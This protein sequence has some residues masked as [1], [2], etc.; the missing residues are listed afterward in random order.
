M[1]YRILSSLKTSVY[2]LSFMCL[3]FLIGTIF[4]QGKDIEEYIEAGGKYI[5]LVRT[6]GFLD[7]FMSP[8]F[9]VTTALLVL[10]LAICIYE[11]FRMFL[12][13]KKK[14]IDLERLKSHPGTVQMENADI[15]DRLKKAGFRFKE[16][17]YDAVQ[18]GIRVYEKGLPYWW[19]SWFYHVGIILAIAGFFI[20]AL[21]AFEEGVVLYPDKPEKISLYSK[22]TRWNRFLEYMGKEVPDEQSGNDYIL[23]LKEFSTEYYQGL[24]LDYPEEK[25]ERLALG[26]GI[27]KLKP[28]EK[29]FSYMPKMW[30]TTLSV[31][32]PDGKVL[33]G[34]LRVNRPFRT[35]A[36]TLYQFGY[37]QYID[38]AVNGSTIEVEAR[39][40]FSV[41]DVSGKFV[42]GSLK[43]GTLL[44][45][46][47]T[48]EKITPFTTLYHIPDDDPS[49]RDKLGEISLGN[50]L[51]ANGVTFEFKDY[52][53]GSYLG[54]RKD[55]GVWLVG[56][57]SL[58]VF[59]GL[60][61]RS[62]GAWYRVQ[63]AFED[64]TAH[65]LVSSRGILADKDRIIKRLKK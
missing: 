5:A 40:P 63:Y 20:T 18:P 30:L 51:E 23:T 27:N 19:L 34:K 16:Q 4:P 49:K 6:L 42:L 54:Y 28:S 9:L 21:F 45:R 2:V 1:L 53:E 35:Q 60:I 38:L 31:K 25:K 65:V 44:K 12:R 37:E 14:P 57:A 8:L 47:G 29:G 62:L 13:I 56:F 58:F 17:T 36:L 15:E 3:I 10:N 39:V 61:L 43:L 33:D 59:L 46:D 22:E 32:R 52:R 55:P 24:E 26:I 11:R 50:K 41:D 64:K 7:I 48:S